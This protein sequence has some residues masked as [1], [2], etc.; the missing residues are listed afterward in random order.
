MERCSV[1]LV[2]T[3]KCLV[4]VLRGE[5]MRDGCVDCAAALSA[6]ALA[7]AG[8]ALELGPAPFCGV[9]RGEL[10]GRTISWP[11]RPASDDLLVA[12]GQP[13]TTSG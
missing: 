1:A 7:R 9:Q 2:S 11:V 12:L 8:L 4:H 5:G 6:S 10:D 13:E 3:P